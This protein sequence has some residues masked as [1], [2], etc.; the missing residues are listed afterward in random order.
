MVPGG[1]VAPLEPEFDVVVAGS[2]A[3]GMT[4]ALTAASRGLS[5]VVIEKTAHF[6]GSTARSGGG[7]WVPCNSVLLRAG[8]S[9]TQEQA[10]RYLAHVAGDDV[11]PLRQQALLE[12]G[13]AMLDL[14]RAATPLEFAW[15]R[16][17][18]DYY[19]EAPG[20]RAGGR[21]IEP[22]PIDGRLLGAE[23]ARLNPPYLPA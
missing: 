7:L 15:V 23:L 4:A 5:V 19:P 2:G 1:A 17:Y 3:A 21:T 16:G 8:V 11:D 22:V 20:G 13:P 12:H 18:A 9:D 6:G 10:R 14:I